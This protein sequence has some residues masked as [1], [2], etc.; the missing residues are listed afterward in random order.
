MGDLL[1]YYKNNF[2][3]VPD[4]TVQISPA[5]VRSVFLRTFGEE[6]RMYRSP[7]RINV[8][9]EH[10]DYNG[11]CVLPSAVDLFTWAAVSARTD[12]LLDIHLCHDGSHHCFSLEDLTPD[13][14]GSAM[15]Y[16]KAVAWA[17]QT[18]G[19]ELQGANLVIGGSIPLGSGL[20]SSASLELVLARVLAD[21]AGLQLNPERLAGLCHKAE[22]DFVGVQCGIMDQYA[23][24]L[25]ASGHAMM[26]DCISH[27]FELL[28]LP[29][30]ARFLLIHS[31]VS[32]QL[33]SGGYN[34]RRDE[35]EAAIGLLAP[36][37]PGLQF[38]AQ[39]EPAQLN[40]LRARLGE[41]LFRRC[42]HVVSECQRVSEAGRALRAGNLEHL[43][44]LIN[45]SHDS[46]RDDYQVSCSE[47]DALVDIARTCDGVLG[48]RMM[49]AGFGGCTI[50][51][52]RSGQVVDCA[53]KIKRKYDRVLGRTPWGHVVGPTGPVSEMEAGNES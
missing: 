28:R 53:R 27:H 39:L 10:L 38:L 20:S 25:G 6:P 16:L 29:D 40:D 46:L 14:S 1:N 9:G 12:R 18:S 7:A 43:G 22:T 3:Q 47:L 31:G 17:M 50:S 34:S 41:R 49:G 24:A 21:Q 4:M 23:I 26:L 45:D 13:H 30:D 48:S 19:L 44:S 32:R 52:V 51:L 11:G 37:I 33:T 15:E 5:E 35:C 8:I 36:F 2:Q 42:R